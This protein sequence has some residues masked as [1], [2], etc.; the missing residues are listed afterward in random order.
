MV[1]D[2]GRGTLMADNELEAI[3]WH[4][5]QNSKDYIKQL[6]GSIKKSQGE[7][8]LSQREVHEKFIKGCKANI[9]QNKLNLIVQRE[10]LRLCQSK[11]NDKPP[12]V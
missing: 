9:E 7:L 11:I 5:A 4:Q 3:W 10:F 6:E 2:F 12:K 1:T 8:K